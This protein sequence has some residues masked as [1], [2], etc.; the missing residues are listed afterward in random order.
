MKPFTSAAV[1]L[2][3]AVCV[4]HVLRLAYGWQVTAADQVIPMWASAVAA[5]VT[6]ALALLVWREN[7]RP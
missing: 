4:V 3:L 2:L 7:R 6:G 5:V 1:I